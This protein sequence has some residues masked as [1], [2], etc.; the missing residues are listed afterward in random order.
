[1]DVCGLCG[2]AARFVIRDLWTNFA[3]SND[4]VFAP[5]VKIHSITHSQFTQ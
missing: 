1:M 2:T 4:E 5:K 3:A